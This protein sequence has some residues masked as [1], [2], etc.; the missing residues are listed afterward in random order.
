[1]VFGDAEILKSS[2]GGKEKAQAG[3]G[4]GKIFFDVPKNETAASEGAAKPF[5]LHTHTRT[6]TP[7]KMTHTH[8]HA[9]LPLSLCESHSL[10]R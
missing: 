5:A 10:N 6:H 2:T 7:H 8:T 9:E 1:M 3:E 4:V